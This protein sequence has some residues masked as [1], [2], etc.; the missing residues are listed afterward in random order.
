M[1]PSRKGVSVP[2]G[3][4]SSVALLAAPVVT[5][6][7]GGIAVEIPAL[8]I[9]GGPTAYRICDS[10]VP[11]DDPAAAYIHNSFADPDMDY[12]VD[13]DPEVFR[14]EALEVEG[15][16]YAQYEYKGQWSPWGWGLDL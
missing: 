2:F 12:V 1:R 16:V 4:Q 9:P 7:N 6:A 8:Q 14:A 10:A 5:V 13:N 11:I 15:Y 3:Q